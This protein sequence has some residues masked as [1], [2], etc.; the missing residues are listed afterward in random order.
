LNETACDSYTLIFKLLIKGKKYKRAGIIAIGV[1]SAHKG[2][3]VAKALAIK[4]Y[5]RHEELGLKKSLYYPVNEKNTESR[6]FAEV[7]TD[8]KNFGLKNIIV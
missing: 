7:R 6:G 8:R 2:K 1:L 3:G 5:S 4:L